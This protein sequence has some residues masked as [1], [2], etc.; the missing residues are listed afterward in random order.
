M[1]KEGNEAKRE[2]KPALD[3]EGLKFP[4]TEGNTN[5]LLFLSS[6]KKTQQRLLL[7]S[8]SLPATAPISLLYFA[9]NALGRVS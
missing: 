5:L 3:V 4:S 6:L 9:A 8:V 2:M 7:T 1:A